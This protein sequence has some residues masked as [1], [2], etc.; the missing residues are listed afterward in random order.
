MKRNAAASRPARARS[1]RPRSAEAHAAILDAAI[2]LTREVGYDALSIEGIAVRACV[3]KATVYRRWRS[4]EALVAEAVGKLIARIPPPNTGTTA[5]DLN[6]LMRSTLALYADSATGPLLSGL[7]AAMARS[8]MI[9]AAVRSG[10]VAAW[11]DAARHVLQRAVARGD[12]R[13]DLDLEI[14]ID[15]LAGPL[16]YRYLL[17]GAPVDRPLANKIV[18]AVTRAFRAPRPRAQ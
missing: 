16:F 14:A 13:R 18:Q 7:V 5:G 11:R 8:R 2:A 1:G 12:L 10:P 4:R 17:T 3:G 15:M 9:A 6:R